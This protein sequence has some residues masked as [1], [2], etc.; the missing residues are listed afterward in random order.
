MASRRADPGIVGGEPPA[1][2][3]LVLRA[4]GF[5]LTD[6][7]RQ[8]STDHLAAKLAKHAG[9]IQSVVIRLGDVNGKRGGEDKTCEVEVHPRARAPFVV[10]AMDHDLRAA[11]DAAADRVQSALGHRLDRRRELPRQRGRKVVRARKLMR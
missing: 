9:Q 3:H 4:H 6:A 5:A 11:I 2:F 7:L 1:G 8:F 10:S